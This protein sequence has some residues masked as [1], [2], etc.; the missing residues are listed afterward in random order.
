MNTH[1]DKTPDNKK[2][3]VSKLLPRQPGKTHVNHQFIDNRPE[4]IA[5][6]KIQ[7]MATEV[8]RERLGSLVNGVSQQQAME[9][10]ELL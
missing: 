5:Q 6:R 4:A 1:A 10:E 3:A 7:A 8:H 2:H 9:D